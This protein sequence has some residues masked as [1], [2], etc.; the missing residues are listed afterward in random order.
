[1][2]LVHAGQR[3]ILGGARGLDH[4]ERQDDED[5]DGDEPRH[6][7]ALDVHLKPTVVLSCNQRSSS[8][9][10]QISTAVLRTS[11]MIKIHGQGDEEDSE[12]DAVSHEDVL[13]LAQK[14]VLL[15]DIG[16]LGWDGEDRWIF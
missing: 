14:P 15:H 4:R 11:V 10:Q 3:P 2:F 5:D 13:P 1:M 6:D 9:C 8:R 16:D 12:G 7:E